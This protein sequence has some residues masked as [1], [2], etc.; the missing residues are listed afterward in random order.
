MANPKQVAKLRGGVAA[1]NGW[2]TRNRDIW[3]DLRGVDLARADLRKVNLRKADLAGANLRGVDLAGADLREANLRKAN[4]FRA[5]LREANLEGADLHEADLRAVDFEKADLGGAILLRADL[6]GAD[7]REANLS[8]ANLDGADLGGVN[9]CEANLSRA[10]LAGADLHEADLERVNFGGA[11]LREVNLTNAVLNETIFAIVDLTDAKGLESCGHYGPSTIDH[12]TL[13]QSGKLPLAFLQGCGL[14]DWEIETAKLYQP[15]LP[16]TEIAEIVTHIH[17]LHAV[18]P[19]Q[20][21]NLFISYT[22]VDNSFVE[23]LESHLR[24]N[25]VRFWRDVHDAPAGPLEK[26]VVRAIRHN[27]TVLLILSAHSVESDW[28]EFEAKQARELEKELDRHVLCPV[29]LDDRWKTCKWDGVLRNQ[30]E[31]YN[32]LDFSRWQ[33]PSVFEEMFKRLLVGLDLFYEK[34]LAE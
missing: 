15:D 2:R 17:T 14:S 28:V 4:L 34:A 24:E 9:F 16:A 26:I 18:S 3:P 29:A 25:H 22:H 20:I 33:D 11:D 32:I 10:D 19:I 31:K 27:P 13:Q 5:D 12:R 1:W 21:H 8:K 30:I 6:A 23:H 7:L